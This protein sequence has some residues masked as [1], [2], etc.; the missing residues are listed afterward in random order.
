RDVPTPVNLTNVTGEGRFVSLEL[1]RN[2]SCASASDGKTYCWGENMSGGLG[3]GTPGD[4]DIPTAVDTTGISEDTFL[5]VQA[6]NYFT[7][8]KS[9]ERKLY[10]WGANSDG[11]QGVGTNTESD[12]PTRPTM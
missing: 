7:C 10:C 3:N 11:Q 6:G 4:V 12:T 9:A 5:D 8:A 1:A 2:Y